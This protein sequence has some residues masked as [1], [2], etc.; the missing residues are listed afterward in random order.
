MAETLKVLGQAKPAA[1]TLTD[2]YAVPALTSA[3]V[4]TITVCE[5]AGVATTFRISVAVA[6]AA[7]APAQYL[8]FDA[9]L[10]AN[11]PI[12]LTIG[13]TLGAGD[14]VRVRSASGSVSFNLFGTQIA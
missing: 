3:V 9:A 12:S 5:Q 8:V 14:V 6:A 7:D 13:V 4:S 1:A 11:E 10:D 2:A